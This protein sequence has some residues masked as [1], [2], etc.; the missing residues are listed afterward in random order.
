MPLYLPRERRGLQLQI[1]QRRLLTMAGDAV[2]IVL[3]VLISLRIW[4]A[5]ARLPFNI[6][7]ILPQVY[8]FFVLVSLWFA[9][10]SANDFYNLRL[11]SRFNTSFSR[12]IQI[13]AQLLVIYL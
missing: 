3:S 1:S 6:D 11:T 2:M 12:L 9:L 13:T 8:W 5:V 10:A 7:F 4:A